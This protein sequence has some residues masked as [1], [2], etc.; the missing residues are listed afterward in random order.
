MDQI[1]V[2]IAI[3]GGGIAGLWTFNQLQKQG[4]HVALLENQ[5][6]GEGQTISSQGIIHGGLKYAL[7][8]ILTPSSSAIQHMP[9]LW[10]NCFDGT[11][12]IDLSGV[13]I[14][15]DCQYLWST[16]NI[17]SN[18]SSFFASRAL[19]GKIAAL[20]PA[21]YPSILKNS[22][23]KGKVYKLNET[24]VDVGS[25]LENLSKFY[26]QNIIKIDESNGCTVCYAANGEISHLALTIKQTP[27][28]LTAAKY[29]F[30]AGRGNQEL[31]KKL[32]NP[33]KMQLRPLRMVYVKAD[34]MPPFHSH[35]IGMSATPRITITS[36]T[37]KDGQG[38]WYL[39]GKLA[40]DGINRDPNDQIK[41]AKQ[42]LS[43]LF[44]W[45]DLTNGS[46]G[47]FVVDRAEATQPLGL[48]PET[49]SVFA[50]NNFIIGWPTKLALAP[51]LSK[52]I[53]TILKEDGISPGAIGTALTNF[54]KPTIA[55]MP[56]E[57]S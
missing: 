21:N 27:Y 20:E 40:E 7:Q 34:Q 22:Q 24:V 26:Q 46:Y 23:F 44:P 32:I 14:L 41:I 16:G 36:H 53:S 52:K 25:L 18:I 37:T 28:K 17:A 2:D 33:P 47:S 39:G 48:K 29:I 8:G 38:V 19:H 55:R 1:T 57:N 45:L 49:E 56:W 54:P 3:V 50:A 9:A 5:A 11:G 12:E 35:C 31:L 6:L 43:Y 4:Y 51:M 13:A 10:Q 42:E 15:S 30:T